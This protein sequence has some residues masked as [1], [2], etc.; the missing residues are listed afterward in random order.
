MRDELD[1]HMG[2][3]SAKWRIAHGI[4]HRAYYIQR[5][6]E[7]QWDAEQGKSESYWELGCLLDEGV[8]DTRGRY[9]V[10]PAQK[11][12]FNYFQ[13]AAELGN[14]SGMMALG[15]CYDC[16]RGVRQSKE[17]ALLYY[18]KVWN[19][20]HDSCAAS[21]IAC[22]HRDLGNLRLA[23]RWYLKAADTG[24]DDD[25]LVD[26]GYYLYY[27][28]GV[29]RHRAKALDAFRQAYESRFITEFG[30]EEAYYHTAVA[31]LEQRGGYDKQQIRELLKSANVDDDYPEARELLAQLNEKI[32]PVPCRCR[33][34]LNRLILGQT[35]CA[36]HRPLGN[37]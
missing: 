2:I 15:Y 10:K 30:R 21:N 7:L 29:R 36:L 11:K 27:G 13:K 25:A 24:V 18:T 33:R 34:H 22:V 6:A 4:R 5:A 17:K 12:A 32:A 9:V 20:H 23:F 19:A 3:A 26:V 8:V 16:G 28:I 1:R 37:K 35:T 31:L 14:R